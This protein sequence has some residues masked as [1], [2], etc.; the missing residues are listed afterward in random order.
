M[1]SV[2]KNPM[3]KEI[4]RFLA[5]LLFGGALFVFSISRLNAETS[6]FK[7]PDTL[8]EKDITTIQS[9][10][11]KYMMQ[12]E[13]YK[14]NDGGIKWLILVWNTA[15]GKSKIYTKDEKKG[16]I[17]VHSGWNVPTPPL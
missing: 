1:N 8:T 17:P 16:T 12:F 7:F 6:N 9:S 15:T 3:I 4:S 13:V 14:N 2:Q 10:N 11:G 5:I